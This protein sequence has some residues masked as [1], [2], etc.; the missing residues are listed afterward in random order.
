MKSIAGA[1]TAVTSYLKAHSEMTEEEI[2]EHLENVVSENKQ[3]ERKLEV[4]ASQ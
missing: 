4:K 1:I 2:A 3:V